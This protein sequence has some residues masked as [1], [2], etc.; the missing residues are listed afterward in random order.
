MPV[1]IYV[2]GLAIFAQGTSE[3]MLS[4]L[5]PAMAHD[6]GVS[7][8]DA[9][10]LISAYAIG[11]VIGA[12]LLAMATLRWPKRR[13]LLTFLAVF[14]A[15]HVVGAVATGYPLLFATRVIGAIACAGFFGVAAVTAVDLVG[16][17]RAGRALSI[18]IGGI[19]VATVLGVPLGTVIGQH[20]G[21]RAAFWTVAVLAALAAIGVAWSLRPASDSSGNET[22]RAVTEF[23]DELRSLADPGL[24]IVYGTS[25]LIFSS[26]MASFSYLGAMLTTDTGLGESWVPVV[27]AL[28][29]VGSL[30]GITLGGRVAD[31]RPFPTLYLGAAGVL[32]CSIGIAVL[33]SHPIP[34]IV[35]VFLMGMFGLATNPA[36]NVRVYAHL[37]EV[38]TLGGALV[39]SAFNVGN[40]I[41]P[42]LAGLA[43]AA[44]LGYPSTAWV[45]AGMA[46]LGLLTVVAGDLRG[47]RVGSDR[48][49]SPEPVLAG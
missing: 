9:G 28:F 7:V 30:I 15:A 42:W 12:P 26:M 3:F 5:L 36:I 22:R 19:T 34:V 13:A 35:L 4:G 48:P 10:L 20:L 40:T 31:A 45:G 23:A 14:I 37:G 44:G 41:A 39:T 49:V 11:M 38:R 43:V 6:L 16:A 8:P 17:H 21:W 29:G 18:V 24:W 33:A 47:R 46:T 27:L 25:A 2:L 1:A 32:L